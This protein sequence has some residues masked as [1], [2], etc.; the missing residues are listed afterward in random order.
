VVLSE[1]YYEIDKPLDIHDYDS[2]KIELVVCSS[3]LLLNQVINNI[4]IE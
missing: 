1:Q 3:Y 4:D 2:N